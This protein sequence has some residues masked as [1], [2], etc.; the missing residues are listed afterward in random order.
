MNRLSRRI[1]GLKMCKI[2]IPSKFYS[3]VQANTIDSL[4]T[5]NDRLEYETL[6]RYPIKD[7]LLNVIGERDELSTSG[8]FNL[9]SDFETIHHDMNQQHSEFKISRK[10]FYPI[11][12]QFLRIGRKINKVVH[13]AAD[14]KRR[15]ILNT[16]RT[17]L[18]RFMS[19]VA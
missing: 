7:N 19:K 4:I 11:F 1:N 8:H 13:M 6:W 15:C 14:K 18:I 16:T 9:F 3:F 10:D 2:K 5:L 17:T 12:V